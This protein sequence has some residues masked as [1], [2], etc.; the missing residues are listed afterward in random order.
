MEPTLSQALHLMN[1]DTVN[2]KIQQGGVLAKLKEQGL[3]PPAAIEDL[4]IRCVGRKPTAEE[5]A[6]LAPLFAEGTN[7]DQAMLDVFWALLNSREFLF[8]H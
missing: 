3:A 2:A 1:G 6:A 8:N 5:Q 4:Y 7:Q